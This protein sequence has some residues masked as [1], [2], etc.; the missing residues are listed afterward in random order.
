MMQ[1]KILLLSQNKNFSLIKRKKTRKINNTFNKKSI[2]NI[3]ILFASKR[4]IVM[5]KISNFTLNYL[6]HTQIL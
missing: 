3:I 2:K 5:P 1:K 4:S 6:I